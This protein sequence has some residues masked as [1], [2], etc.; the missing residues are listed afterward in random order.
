MSRKALNRDLSPL[1]PRVFG[2]S[3]H[4]SCFINP[5]G[6]FFIRPAMKIAIKKTHVEAR[7]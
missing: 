1:F 5:K 7:N 3:W 4:G 6:L 2:P